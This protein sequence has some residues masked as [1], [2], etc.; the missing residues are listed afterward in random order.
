[1]WRR[2]G[3]AVASGL[4]VTAAFP[5]LD[6]GL[7]SLVAFIPLLWAWRDATPKRAALYGLAWGVAFFSVLVSWAWYF[8]AVA[9]AP[10][11]V[12]L[13][14]YAAISGLLVGLFAKR[15]IRS[16]WLT[17]AVWVTLEALRTRWPVGGFAWGEA[18]VSLHSVAFGRALASWGGVPLVSFLILAWNGL[19][20]DALTG[21]RVRRRA[22]AAAGTALIVVVV[23]AGD[24]ARF[25]PTP[26][27]TLRFALLQGNNLDRVLTPEEIAA[28]YLTNQHFRLAD[29]LRGHY[30]LIVFP[31]SGLDTDPEH[32]PAL[33]ARIVALAKKHDSYVLVNALTPAGGVRVFN[34]NLLYDP[35][36]K[37]QGTYS[38][39][40]LVPY[41]EYV[42]FRQQ[43]SFIQEL[44]QIPHDFKAGTKRRV[45]EVNRHKIGTVVCFE[46]AFGPLVRGFVRDGAQAIVVTTNNRSY[47]RSANSAQHL[48][49]SQMRAA[50]TARP[51]LHD[52]IS[53]STAVIDSS[54]VVHQ[55]TRLFHNAVVA[56]RITTERGET[57][58]VRYGDWVEWACALAVL[59]AALVA[60][61]RRRPGS[62][63]PAADV[64]TV[65]SAPLPTHIPV[66]ERL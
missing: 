36:G 17:A 39:Q 47:R 66:R 42:P 13:A 26:T 49:L 63:S 11:V 28:Q 24:V 38:K 12:V 60:C 34:T 6:F 27:G 59:A 3:A 8:G 56:G 18:G 32:D 5:P 10:L 51:V 21:A 44:Q 41:G 2:L 15:G 62:E 61:T 30:D 53:G 1:M 65:E 23:V 40:H 31:E 57:P 19:L 52:S 29:T 4:L 33:R 54:G 37:L 43:L 64:R 46:S 25:E 45:F 58:Y 20:L 9:I 7:L 55:R 16:P 48:A 35:D 50:E 14:S 22:F